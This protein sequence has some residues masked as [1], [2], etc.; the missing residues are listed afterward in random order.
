MLTKQINNMKTKISQI[1]RQVFFLLGAIFLITFSSCEKEADPAP[2]PVASFQYEISDDNYLEV[3][4]TSFSQN[5]V[6]Y[7]W[8][9]GDGGTSTQENPTHTYA[10]DGTY[11][12][13]LT[14][15][16]SDGVSHS[17]S[18]TVQ[19]T[20]P[21]EALKL[22]TGDVSKTWK[23]YREGSS[24]GVGENMDDLRGWFALEND[25]TRPCMYYQEFTFLLDGTYVFDDKGSFWGE[26][27]VFPDAMVGECF[28]AVPANMV[29]KDGDDL[30]AWLGDTH[31]F[32]YDPSTG[33]VTL[34]GEGAWI[35]LVKLGTDGEVTVP[36]NSVSFEIS[37]EEHTGYDLMHI[38][39]DYGWGIWDATYASYSDPSLEP[40]VVSFI[41]D[42]S[43]K[44]DDKTVTF[45]N[46]SVDAVSYIWDFGDGNTS[47]V[48]NPVHTYAADGA[49][50]VVLTGT[51][52]GGDTKEVTKTVTIDTPPAEVAPAPTVPEGDVISIYSDAYTDIAG[53]NLNP[54]WGQ[55]TVT[56]EI[57]ITTDEM[58]LKMAGLNYQGI[59]WADNPQD[60]S[61]KTYL[62]VDIY[63]SSVTEINIS[64]ISPGQENA[65]TITT[66]ADA[67]KSIDIPLSDYTVPDLTGVIQLKFDDAG[68][69]ASPTI[70]VDNIYFH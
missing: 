20:D 10:E 14:V 54:D 70:Y 7:S 45:E 24:L 12:V 51:D 43:F 65:V 17:F 61:G 18:R 4:F 16:N 48:E 33:M 42:F 1:F 3:S 56:E 47:T 27:G 8:D 28:E 22:L 58:V 53:V 49:Y 38:I 68:T 36:Q 64:V 59:D 37:I 55:A 6:A 11:E 13:R 69:E 60:V 32:E 9:F 40:E 44:V 57:E 52:A 21:E 30:S 41:V 26:G 29:G 23:L 66:E 67:W 63:S 31:S 35:G 46:N 2:D 25:G 50:A 5:A 15:E 62:H 19:I 34:I 39:F